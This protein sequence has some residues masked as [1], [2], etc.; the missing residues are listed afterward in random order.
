MELIS[1]EII[2]ESDTY[3]IEKDWKKTSMMM[4]G[5][6]AVYKLLKNGECIY[7]D[8]PF[9]EEDK[10]SKTFFKLEEIIKKAKSLNKKITII[11]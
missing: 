3:K 2:V 9:F 5:W 10:K 4:F 1:K 8:E 6:L 7:T 11:K